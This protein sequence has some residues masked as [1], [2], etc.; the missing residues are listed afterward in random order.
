MSRSTVDPAADF[1][2]LARRYWSSWSQFA[3]QPG[4]VPEV[5]GWKDGLAWWSQLAGQGRGD[6]EA[7]LER[8]NAQAGHWF[9]SMQQLAAG[10]AGREAGAADITRAWRD[11]LGAGGGNPLS[12]MFKR[13]GGAD[14]RG[15]E[16]WMAQAAPF[17]AGLR[18]EA[19]ALL[20]LPAFGLAREHQERLQQLAQAQ[21]AYQERTNDYQGQ[22]ARAAKLAFE[23][24]EGKLAEHSEPG[25]QIES[26]RALF[27]LWIDAAEEAWAEVALSPEYR[28]VYGHFVNAQMRLRAGLQRE[29]ELAAG[30]FGLPTRSEINASHR[31]LAAL[32]RE[33]RALKA[34]LGGAAGR[35]V[36]AG[37]AVPGA[38]PDAAPIR[39]AAAGSGARVAKKPARKTAPAK[40]IAAAEKRSRAGTPAK[41]TPRPARRMALP[42]VVAPTALRASAATPRRSNAKKKGR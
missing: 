11:A 28:E 13:M 17:L 1:E 8:M 30:L 3:G 5:P 32:E 2:Q 31:K 7:A 41:A 39:P 29:I 21:L 42:Q 35:T 4:A 33:L 9:G 26:A 25:R 38:K 20:N 23:R 18:G 40:H 24:F 6:V 16:D 27:D 34:Q 15:V 36:A 37:S 22:L 14:A 19:G 12:E 10:F